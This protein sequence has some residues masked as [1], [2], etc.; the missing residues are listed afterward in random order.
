[1]HKL[2]SR[3]KRNIISLNI[4][5]YFQFYA[6]INIIHNTVYDVEKSDAHDTRELYSSCSPLNDKHKPRYACSGLP[7]EIVRLNSAERRVRGWPTTH[8]QNFP[9]YADE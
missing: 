6:A 5:N 1:M 7:I 2:L 8:D 9:C 3:L 4:G